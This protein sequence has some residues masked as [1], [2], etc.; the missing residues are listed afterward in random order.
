[1]RIYQKYFTEEKGYNHTNFLLASV[2]A[3][4]FNFTR[5]FPVR[6]FYFRTVS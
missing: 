3:Y 4:Y 5:T 6:R 2:S 1:M